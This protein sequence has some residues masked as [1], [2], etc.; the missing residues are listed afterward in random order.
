MRA[1]SRME[2]AFM[3]PSESA[4]TSALCACAKWCRPNTESMPVRMP[5]RSSA[6]LT[7]FLV[8]AS[9]NR[10]MA[11]IFS[12]SAIVSAS[13]S[14]RGTTR[15]TMPHSL[16]CAAPNR[17]PVKRNSLA[18]RGPSTHGW[19]KYSTPGMP[20]RTTG[21]EK[22]ASSEATIRSHTQA[23]ISPP[24]MQAPCTIAMVGFGISRQRRHMPR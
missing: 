18:A 6:W 1:E 11:A 24:A 19:A 2:R 12:A 8:S 15:F 7:A 14:A 5:I 10:G 23:S 3:P 4:P 16:A 20:M 17:S 13:S 21:S 22:N 9:P